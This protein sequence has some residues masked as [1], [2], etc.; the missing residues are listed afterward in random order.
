MD[1]TPGLHDATSLAGELRLR[2]RGVCKTPLSFDDTRL[3]EP[4]ARSQEFLRSVPSTQETSARRQVIRRSRRLPF[5]FRLH[6]EPAKVVVLQ[7]A[8]P[9]NGVLSCRDGYR[10]EFAALRCQEHVPKATEIRE[11]GHQS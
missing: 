4:H 8:Q 5:T 3:L 6:V 1:G 10:S 7:L 9:H 2:G 11:E